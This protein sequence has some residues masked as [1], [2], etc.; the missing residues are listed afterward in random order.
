MFSGLSQTDHIC[1][2]GI[3]D[4]KIDVQYASYHHELVSHTSCFTV[5]KMLSSV[6]HIFICKVQM[7]TVLTVEGQMR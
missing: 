6:V 4:G 5:A 1:L 3:S 2:G 7:L